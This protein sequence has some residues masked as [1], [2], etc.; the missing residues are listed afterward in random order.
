M[1]I[2]QN[3]TPDEWSKVL[4][5]EG[6]AQDR[7]FPWTPTLLD[8]TADCASTLDLG[9][10]R[11]ELAAAMARAGKKTTLLDWSEKN[12]QFSRDLF[13]GLELE[14]SF[15]RADMTQPLSFA[16]GQFDA[17]HSCGVF[18]YFTDGEIVNILK[19]A[20]RVARKRVIILV[21]NAW[22]LPYR[23]GKWYL[24]Q[25]KQ[26]VWGGERPFSSL[27][28]HFRAAGCGGIREFSVG[29]KH[30]LNFLTMRGGHALQSAAIVLFRLKDHPRPSFLNQGYLLITAGEKK[31]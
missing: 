10:G 26:W 5:T 15:H 27:K 12:I 2:G 28:P 30:S 14:G 6:Q 9:S 11:G 24:E 4:E 22:S 3:L 18:E 21:P 23:F 16:D 19:E 31:G 7:L 1:A 20:F 17:V 29:T 8:L 25:T 13:L